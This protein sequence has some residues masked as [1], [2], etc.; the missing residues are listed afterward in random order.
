MAHCTLLLGGNVG[1]T[2]SIIGDAC[3]KIEEKVGAV[4]NASS[5]YAS[6]PWGFDAEQWFINQ[7]LI[8]N[9]GLNAKQVLQHTQEIEREMGRIKISDSKRF[10]SRPIDI[11]ILFYDNLVINTPD[12]KVPHPMLHLRRFTLLPLVE[13]MPDFVHPSFDI[14]IKK[15]LDACT[16]QGKVKNI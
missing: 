14:S 6:E 2:R 12:L 5:L 1:N 10:H 8:V 3:L 4:V 11:D 9:T 13:L 16:D 7:V 15:I